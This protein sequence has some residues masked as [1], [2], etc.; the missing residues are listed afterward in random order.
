MY[1]CAFTEKQR[2]VLGNLPLDQS[3]DGSLRRTASLTVCFRG[4]GVGEPGR[5]AWEAMTVT[6]MRKQQ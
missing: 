4:V 6:E 3:A 2:V 1:W 5:A